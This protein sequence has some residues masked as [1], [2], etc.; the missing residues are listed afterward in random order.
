MLRTA[1]EIA[2]PLAAA[3]VEKLGG[4]LLEGFRELAELGVHAVV[5]VQFLSYYAHSAD[6]L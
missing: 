5:A 6:E 3:Y 1:Q 2:E 4:V